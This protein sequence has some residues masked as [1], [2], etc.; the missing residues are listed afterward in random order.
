MNIFRKQV[1]VIIQPDAMDCGPTCLKMICE[2]YGQYVTIQK[3]R[4]LTKVSKSGVSIYA[5][6]EA[7]KQIGFL[8]TCIKSNVESVEV[9]ATMPS[10]LHWN[11]NHYVILYKI[12]KGKYYLIDPAI[13]KLEYSIEEFKSNWETHN[14]EGVVLLLENTKTN[15]KDYF[16]KNEKN[17]K[18][19]Y[20]LYQYFVKQK[21]LFTQLI[22]AIVA[23]SLIQ[24]AFPFLTQNIVDK[25]INNK[26][27]NFLILVL[28][29]Q[30]MLLTGRVVIDFLRSWILL[31]ISVRINISLLKDFLSKLMKLPM[32][33]FDTKNM[34]DIFNRIAD[35]KRIEQ[36]LTVTSLSTI[37]SLI[38]FLVFSIMLLSYNLILFFI[39]IV[40]SVI[41]FLWSYYFLK[42]RKELDYK[43]FNISSKNQNNLLQIV[44]GIHEIKLN[45]A[46]K[47]KMYNWENVQSDMFEI[48]TK[49]LLLGQVQQSGSFMINEFKNITLTFLTAYSVIKGEITLGQMMAIQYIIGQLNSPIN[50]FISLLNTYQDA[51]ISMDRVNEIHTILD[52]TQLGSNEN[53]LLSS[54]DVLIKEMSF[55]YPGSIINALQDINLKIENGKTT[56]IVGSSGSGKTTLLKLI[57]KYYPLTNGSIQVG[58]INLNEINHT[59]WRKQC[60]S[61][62]QDGYIFSD[63]IANNISP[64][65]LNYDKEKMNK[66]VKLA[67]IEEF[68]ETLPSGINTVIG[69]EGNGISQGQKQRLLIARSFYKNPNLIVFDEATNSL[70][71]EN[72]NIIMKNI[73]EY[74]HGKTMIVVAHRLSTVKEADNIVV[75]DKGKVV[76]MGTHLELISQQGRYFKLIKNQLEI[77]NE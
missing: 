36:F 35:H 69:L 39:S 19:F 52:E 31:H 76:E 15:N 14:S 34:G 38:T 16:A 74:F 29:G 22:I 7:A 24:V 65:T 21:Q 4:E 26:D 32:S 62:L 56:A 46:E 57:L 53:L 75:L 23:I 11:H 71:T 77:S 49:S 28:V 5:I 2:Y 42:K 10:I 61:V 70:D 64:A 54:Q 47:L 51:K 48:D 18:T 67:N 1:P 25:G 8:T 37:F 20:T 6:S 73:K 50:Q 44:E 72:E 40:A 59:L 60:G 55:C 13:G 41:Y 43:K 63:T 45:N 66:A 3:L 33:F 27:V 58:N 17:K 12:K 68:I 30:F 9:D